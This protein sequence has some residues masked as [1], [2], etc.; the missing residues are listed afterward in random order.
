MPITIGNNIAS[1]RAIRQLDSTANEAARVSERLASGQRINRASDDAAGLSIAAGLNADARVFTQSIRNIG[2]AASMLNIAEGALSTLTDIVTKQIALSEQAANGVYSGRQR[3]AL[4]REANA[5]RKEY[6]RIVEST[7]FNGRKL[8]DGNSSDVWI[9][10][11]ENE[12]LFLS[13][14]SLAYR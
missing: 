10:G 2:D 14:C 5:L 3:L 11:R 7:E 8:L 9:M 12:C 4:E 13:S 1:L 6:N